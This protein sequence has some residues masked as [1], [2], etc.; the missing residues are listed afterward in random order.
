MKD[1]VEC[2]PTRGVPWTTSARG[3]FPS[4]VRSS[5]PLN[6]VGRRCRGALISRLASAA[7]QAGARGQNIASLDPAKIGA[8]RQRRPTT[9]RGSRR[10]VRLPEV[11]LSEEEDRSEG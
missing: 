9:F 7:K 5:L 4:G 8:S 10:E 3:L 6:S 2:V 11:L 1:A